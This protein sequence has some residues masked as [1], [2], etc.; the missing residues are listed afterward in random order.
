M[1]IVTMGDPNGIGP[2]IICRFFG[3]MNDYQNKI[4]IVGP[5]E[6]LTYFCKIFSIDKFWTKV[7]NI[8]HL[9]EDKIYLYDNNLYDFKFK[10]GIP[11]KDAGKVS[12]KILKTACYLIKNKISS[13]LV[14][15]PINKSTLIDAGFNFPGH[16]EFLASEFG[17]GFDDICMHLCGEKL[18][19]SLVTTHPPLKDVPSIISQEKIIRCL[20]LTW[21]MLCKLKQNRAPI[22]V[23]GLN[24][25]AGENGK[26]GREEIEIIIP[27]IVKAKQKGINVKGPYPADT[28]FYRAYNGEFSAVLAM[29]HDQGLAPLKLVDFN[30]AVNVTLGLPFV[31]TSVDHGTAYELVGKGIANTTSFKNALKLAIDLI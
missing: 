9:T 22:G 4:L 31:R 17:L 24:P 29:Y 8:D 5:E 7:D 19:V 20:H 6:P 2:E 26:I 14:T 18:K 23:C 27:A 1:I 10:P 21:D 11:S 16:T 25:H 30:T 3:G 15:C 12:G 13:A 28:I